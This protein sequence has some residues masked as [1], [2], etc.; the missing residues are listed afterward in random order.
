MNFISFNKITDPL[1]FA[2]L[3]QPFLGARSTFEDEEKQ[4]YNTF[5]LI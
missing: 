3:L 4:I 1:H 2:K 5:T